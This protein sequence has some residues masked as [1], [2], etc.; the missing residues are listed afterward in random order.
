M[1]Q[2]HHAAAFEH[3]NELTR[4][5]KDAWDRSIVYNWD[6]RELPFWGKIKDLYII[7]EDDIPKM[8]TN[9]LN[10]V[11]YLLVMGILDDYQ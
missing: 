1:Y 10:A 11:E 5:E 4:E 3:I 2:G 9:M 8:A 7:K 6:P